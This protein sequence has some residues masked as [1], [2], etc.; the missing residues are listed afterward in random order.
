MQLDMMIEHV[1]KNQYFLCASDSCKTI[2]KYYSKCL[3]YGN[4]DKFILIT[5]YNQFELKDASEQF[6]GKFV[7]YSP[8]IIFGVDFS[9][10]QSQ[11]V[12]IINKGRTLD[13]SAIF[14]QTTRTRNI[15]NLYYYS[16]LSNN[17]PLYESFDDCKQMYLNIRNKSQ[18]INEVCTYLDE[19]DNEKICENTFFDLF[20]YNEYVLDIY[21]TNKTSHYQSILRS[22]GFILSEM[23]TIKKISKQVQIELNE[24]IIQNREDAFNNYLETRETDD[25]TLKNNLGMLKIPDDVDSE[26]LEKYKSIIMDKFKLEE[27]LD[28]IRGCKEEEFVQQKIFDLERDNYNVTVMGST[29]HKIK[30]IIKLEQHMKIKRYQV[31]VKLDDITFYDIPE[32]EYK[33]IC[34]IFRITRAKPSDIHELFKMY[35]SMLRNI[36]TSEIVI[37]KQNTTRANKKMSYTLNDKFIKF[38][39]EL[40][41]FS[42]PYLVNFDKYLLNSINIEIPKREDETTSKNDDFLDDVEI[43]NPLDFGIN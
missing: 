6:N 24:P 39:I 16:E 5:A 20:C 35:V 31:D 3:E 9:I 42:N 13:P 30:H 14:Q 23:G 34:K 40:N 27:H 38:H 22:N 1:K 28:I 32:N 41:M 37:A 10:E 7:F 17:D 33:L 4:K 36:M 26:I 8:S 15:Q 11:D 19:D 29:Y 21:Q 18:E 2:Q 25:L 12:F 43:E